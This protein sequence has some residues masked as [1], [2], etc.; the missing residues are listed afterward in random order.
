MQVKGPLAD[1]R[2]GIRMSGYTNTILARL[3]QVTDAFWQASGLAR[4]VSPLASMRFKHHRIPE[5]TSLPISGLHVRQA[6]GRL[7]HR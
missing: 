4:A 3:W 2:L 7:R 1:V 5:L 6:A